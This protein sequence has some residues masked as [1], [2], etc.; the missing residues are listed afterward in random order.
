MNK[1]L[2]MILANVSYFEDF[3]K[4]KYPMI[5]DEKYREKIVHEIREILEAEIL[6]QEAKERVK[7]WLLEIQE[8]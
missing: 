4:L 3:K 1:G 7:Q 6:D 8:T 5:P 2:Q